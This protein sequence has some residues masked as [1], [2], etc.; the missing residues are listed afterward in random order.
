MNDEKEKDFIVSEEKERGFIRYVL[1]DNDRETI[2]KILRSYEPAAPIIE[3]LDSGIQVDFKKGL[4]VIQGSKPEECRQKLFQ[5]VEPLM[6]A[7]S[8]TSSARK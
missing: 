8:T 3:A 4:I 2:I 7:R 6:S 1:R 5:L